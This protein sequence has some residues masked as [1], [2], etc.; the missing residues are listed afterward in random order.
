MKR[1]M[2][3]AAVALI[4]M[5]LL[6]T[7]GCRRVRI[8]DQPGS[9]TRVDTET[10]AL[11]GAQRVAGRVRI[12]IGRLVMSGVPSSTAALDARF[13]YSPVTWKPELTSD[14]TSATCT[15]S[16]SQP[17]SS[18]LPILGRPRNEWD[19]KLAGGVPTDLSLEL[20]V[21]QSDI[22]LSAVDIRELKVVTGVGEATI[23]LS[24]ARTSDVSGNIQ[25]G[26]GATTIKLPAQV[27]VRVRG[28][29]EGV[30]DVRADGFTH[31]GN[32]F[33]NAA[34]AGTGPK[35]DISLD[36]GVGDLR[37]VLVD[38]AQAQ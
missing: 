11:G 31:E 1:T 23:D 29:G 13:T 2:A 3:A 20:G 30:G 28:A 27:G 5:G 6:A 19:L 15:Y 16:V 35:I 34:W 4:L 7:T 21:G 22:D 24:G 17:D 37:L 18:D 25:T 32:D 38:N 36:H 9:Q 14:S 26:V 10:V 12:G 33:V 8:E